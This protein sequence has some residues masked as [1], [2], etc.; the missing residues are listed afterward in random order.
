MNRYLCLLTIL[1][2]VTCNTCAAQ[3]ADSARTVRS[4]ARCWRVISHEYAN[5]YGLE[6][7][8]I[9]QY[10]K[11]KVCLSA[12]SIVIFHGASYTPKYSVKKVS[13]EEYARNNFDCEKRKLGIS[14]DSVQE[15][16]ISSISKPAKDGKT[17][18]MTDI[19]LFDGDCIYVVA[20][21]VIFRMFDADA[22]VVPRSSK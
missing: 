13:A 9:Q 8:E 6:E 19:I 21:G 20:D 17:H 10:K 11:Q 12:D 16:T 3:A 15:I 22:K 5:I 4:L 14:I 2:I 7:E 1:L 18:K